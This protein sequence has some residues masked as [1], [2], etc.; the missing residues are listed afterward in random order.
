MSQCQNWFL[1]EK[2]L[3]GNGGYKIRLHILCF[4]SQCTPHPLHHT[5]D[6]WVKYCNNLKEK[7]EHVES[8]ALSSIS[9]VCYAQICKYLVIYPN[10]ALK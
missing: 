2:Y 10:F 1:L 3:F 4:R 5:N 8:G 9:R 6:Q 7:N